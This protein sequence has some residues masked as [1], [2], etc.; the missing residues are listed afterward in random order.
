VPV[1]G[2]VV[3]ALAAVAIAA[4]FLLGHS[5]NGSTNSRFTN[6]AT[7]GHLQLRYPST[8]QLSSA[9]AAIPGIT[10]TDPLTL[11]PTRGGGGL[12]A[13]TVAD[14]GGS[15]LLSSSFRAKVE[16]T[17]PSP[18]SVQLGNVQAYNYQDLKVQGLSAP[19]TVYA[20][21]STDGVA[22]IACSQPTG[23]TAPTFRSQCSEVADTLRLLG[24][25]AYPLG[26]STGDARAVSNVFDRLNSA[27]KTPL[28]SLKAASTPTA[29]A[30]AYQQLAGA[31]RTAENGLKGTTL[32]PQLR[33]AKNATAAALGQ[34]ADGYS[35][36]GS[37][38]SAGVAGAYTRA[39]KQ[40][41]DGSTALTAAVKEFSALGY[42]V[43]Q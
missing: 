8:W 20:V 1:L 30:S 42:A 26:V 24:V 4:G 2:P 39:S 13:G 38:A 31:Y 14:A 41:S 11:A 36:A 7:V 33:D 37:A 27:V 34:I 18:S 23:T 5:G 3:V 15:T 12:D 21:P 35:A 28:A 17:L 25:T 9:T 32:S 10:F 6:S 29:Q 16:G 43:Q 19:V 40:V 22:T